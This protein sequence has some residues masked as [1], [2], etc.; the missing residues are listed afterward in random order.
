[1]L[2]IHVIVLKSVMPFLLL[3]QFVITEYPDY[4]WEFKLGNTAKLEA[5]G[6][7]FP[8]FWSTDWE[9]ESQPV[10]KEEV[11]FSISFKL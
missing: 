3:I 5:S 1:M 6:I 10:L 2:N 8:N 9:Y 4:K 7:Q 11:R